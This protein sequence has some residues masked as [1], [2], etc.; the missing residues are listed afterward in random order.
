MLNSFRLCPL[1]SAPKV[2]LYRLLL[3]GEHEALIARQPTDII[4]AFNFIVGETTPYL[5]EVIT[6]RLYPMH[7]FYCACSFI[8]VYF[9]R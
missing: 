9:C 3:I 7:G 8:L 2:Y 5:Q 1:H 4:R 6:W